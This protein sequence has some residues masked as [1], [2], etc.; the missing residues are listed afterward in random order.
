MYIIKMYDKD[1]N[2]I[3]KET[4]PSFVEAKE[5][6][7]LMSDSYGAIAEKGYICHVDTRTGFLRTVENF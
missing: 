5:K 7:M 2:K 6:S 3:V 4:A 1:N